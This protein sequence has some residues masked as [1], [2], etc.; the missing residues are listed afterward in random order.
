[1]KAALKQTGAGTWTWTVRLGGQLPKGRYKLAFR[2]TDGAGNAST[3]LAGGR[4]SV[5]R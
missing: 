1:M 5:I 3:A 2:A 4:S